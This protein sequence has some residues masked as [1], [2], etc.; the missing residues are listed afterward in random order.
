MKLSTLVSLPTEVSK[1][2]GD[3]NLTDT[4]S[5]PTKST[6]HGLLEHPGNGVVVALDH[7]P[8]FSSEDNLTITALIP[9]PDKYIAFSR[10]EFI[11]GKT[12]WLDEGDSLY[13]PNPL[14]WQ[15]IQYKRPDINHSLDV[16]S[17]DASVIFPVEK[18]LTDEHDLRLIHPVELVPPPGSQAFAIVCQKTD[19]AFRQ[20][21]I[22][23]HDDAIMQLS[24]IE[25]LLAKYFYSQG[26]DAAV[27]CEKQGHNVFH[28]Y[29]FV[30]TDNG[31]FYHHT[32][33]SS[34]VGL[35]TQVIS[36][37]EQHQNIA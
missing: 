3:P 30:D 20:Q 11:T 5:K 4:V 36:A 16:S 6:L 28:L 19:T 7:L 23:H 2:L 21:M 12:F 8:F 29:V 13:C 26:L 31:P 15:Q 25:R 22:I 27:R 10:K 32:R 24:N 33:S 37:Y 9:R 14:L 17:A 1:T 18:V 35:D 34:W